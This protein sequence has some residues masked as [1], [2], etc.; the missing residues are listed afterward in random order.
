MNI[1]VDDNF[2]R[3]LVQ[4]SILFGTTE[5]SALVRAVGL[6]SE[7]NRLREGQCMAILD[8]DGTVLKTISP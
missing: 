7:F 3:P 5:E 2:R 6:L 4:H 1:I 8:V